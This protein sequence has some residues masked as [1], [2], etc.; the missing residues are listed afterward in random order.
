MKIL[1]LVPRLPY[2]P[3]D[4]GK[5][6]ILGIT[7]GYLR[8]GHEVRLMG[9]DAD[10]AEA[11]FAAGLGRE[12]AGYYVEPMPRWKSVASATRSLL[13]RRPFLR[14]KY[15]SSSM[16]DA[17]CAAYEQWRPDF[18]HID[19]SH[20]GAYGLEL[21][22]R[23]RDARVYLRAHNV[24]IAIWRRLKTTA[25]NAFSRAFYADQARLVRDYERV[26]FSTLDGVVPLTPVDAERVMLEAP[27]AA[28]YTMP[29]G[30]ELRD[31][32]PLRP[33]IGE[34]PRLCFVGFLDWIANRDGI[35]WFVED[36]WPRIRARWP[37]ARLDVVGRASTPI[38]CLADTPGVHYHGYVDD[39]DAVLR[40]VDVAVVP[41]RI[42]GGMRI[43]ILDFLS[44]GLPT[45]STSVGA[46]GIAHSW[47][48]QHVFELADHADGFLH[49]LELLSEGAARRQALAESGRRFIEHEFDWTALMTR[50]C[51]WVEAAGTARVPDEAPPRVGLA[52]A[53]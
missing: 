23:H 52:G 28:I 16:F 10:G 40:N 24:E 34:D 50:F 8:A 3:S 20:M 19:H 5:I 27:D 31:A 11:S 32:V 4:G 42:G 36:V 6:G 48:G 33:G 7:R 45:I 53:V 22:R 2:P 51:R 35:T 1:Q 26:L 29:A 12:L 13:S 9:F 49:A 17:V 41:L 18:V 15:W 37:N 39:L 14:E 21:K 47:H 30:C 38:R 43:K 44:R 46:E 25:G